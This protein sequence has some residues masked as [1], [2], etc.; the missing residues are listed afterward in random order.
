MPFTKETAAE[1]GRK[2]AHKRHGTTA[3]ADPPGPPPGGVA[4]LDSPDETLQQ[5]AE[6]AGLLSDSYAKR[7]ATSQTLDKVAELLNNLDPVAHAELL[8]HPVVEKL[9]GEV[10][11]AKEQS[12]ELM[13]GSS[14][15]QAIGKKPWT[16][17]DLAEDKMEW[18]TYTPRRTVP[19]TYNGLTYYFQEDVTVRCPK[20][21]VDIEEE[22]RRNTRLGKEHLDYMFRKRDTISDPGLLAGGSMA[23][24]GKVRG[25]F[26]GGST[27]ATGLDLVIPEADR[28]GFEAIGEVGEGTEGA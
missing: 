1:L 18:A 3:V 4:V 16:W 13:P 20:C 7:K 25:M 27:G 8:S 9:T 17:R 2:G 22:S 23:G 19:V 26:S 5:L 28:P 21:F 6:F 12:G 10:I 15:G 24:P 11:K 14:L